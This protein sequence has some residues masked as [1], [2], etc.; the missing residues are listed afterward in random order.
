ME[1]FNQIVSDVEDFLID[2]GVKFAM[3]KPLA[4]VIVIG[5]PLVLAGIVLDVFFG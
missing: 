4:Y 2:K 5:V 1:K 3:A